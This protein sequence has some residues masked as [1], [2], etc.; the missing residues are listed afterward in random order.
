MLGLSLYN[1][2]VT[3][4]VV[5]IGLVLA[6]CANGSTQFLGSASGWNSAEALDDAGTYDSNFDDTFLDAN[7]VDNTVDL[8]TSTSAMNSPWSATF[9]N[10]VA[11]GNGEAA[12]AIGSFTNGANSA[13]YT[14]FLAANS[15][16]ST[17]QTG[18]G[19][20]FGVFGGAYGYAESFFEFQATQSMSMTSIG[21]F[22]ATGQRAQVILV[23]IDTTD[24][25]QTDILRQGAGT[26]NIN[27]TFSLTAGDYYQLSSVVFANPGFQF[28]PNTSLNATDVEGTTGYLTTSFQA[29]PEPLSFGLL[30]LGAVALLK[31]RRR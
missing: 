5:S 27:A 6:F 19:P 24:G 31:R 12:S 22:T 9:A 1:Q 7:D 8:G 14:F 17:T 25:T 2:R 28:D 30:G 18:P 21:S 4:A 3:R 10:G 29:T 15:Q 16:I 13:G 20:Y 23:F 26:Y 11:S